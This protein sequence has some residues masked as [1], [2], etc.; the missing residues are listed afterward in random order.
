MRST[1]T[2]SIAALA[3]VAVMSGTALAGSHQKLMGDLVI[4][5]DTSNP[6]PRATME[7]AIAKFQDMQTGMRVAAVW[8][9]DRKGFITDIECFRPE[10]A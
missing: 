9:A 1:L 3:T 8:R 4:F 6:A 10:A 2:A 5:L 7:A